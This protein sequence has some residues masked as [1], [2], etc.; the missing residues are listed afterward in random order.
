MSVLHPSR[1][2]IQMQFTLTFSDPATISDAGLDGGRAMLGI[3]VYA[4]IL[5]YGRVSRSFGWQNWV[6]LLV[7]AFVTT[8]LS[9][10]MMNITDSNQIAVVTLLQFAILAV[11]YCLGV[12]LGR[13]LD[14]N[15]DLS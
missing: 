13:W 6:I 11:L 10:G 4:A 12:G 8:L 9:A 15:K 14:R 1:H 3:A 5:A 2:P 7:V